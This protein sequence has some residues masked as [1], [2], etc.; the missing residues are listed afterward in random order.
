[1]QLPPG[2]R[3][4][5]YEVLAPIE[6]G[7]MG[8]VYRG[9]D[10]RLLRDVA[11]KVLPV[12]MMRDERAVERFL[13]EARA[14]AALSHPNIVAIH[15]V[16]EAT[17]SIPG[18]FGG[19]E[20]RI[21][22]LV[23]EYVD[24]GS[25]RRA[26]KGSWRPDVATAVGWAIGILRALSA[27]HDKGLIHRDLKP[28]N[29][30]VD[31]QGNA[32]IADFGLV[33]WIYP[34]SAA[35][36]PREEEPAGPATL[37][38]TGFVVGTLGYMSP[39]QVRGEPVDGRSD[40]FAFGVLVFE[41]L[42][43]SSPFA[44][45]SPDTALD[46]V[47]N[48][49]PSSLSVL[50]AGVP[51]RLAQVVAWCLEK[52]PGKRPASA[53]ALL[54]HLE[55]IQRELAAAPVEPTAELPPLPPPQ[56]ARRGPSPLAWLAGALAV[57]LA[58]AGGFAAGRS[59]PAPAPEATL[60]GSWTA[61]AVPLPQSA[62]AEL[63]LLPS[64][65]K[66]LLGSGELLDTTTG[67]LRPRAL[68]GGLTGLA[69]GRSGAAV[70][71]S[72][73]AG[74]VEAPLPAGTPL[75]TLV[76]GA[77]EPAFSRD[78]S[79][80]AYVRREGGTSELWIARRDATEARRVARAEAT[81]WAWPAFSADGESLL[82]FDV[83]RGGPHAGT[84]YLFSVRIADGTPVPFG[85]DVRLDP[86]GRPAVTRDGSVAVLEASSRRALLLEREGRSSVALPFGAGL[87]LL[88]A[89]PEGGT[90]ATRSESGPLV[91]WRRV[92]GAT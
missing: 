58:F 46:A 13:R 92:P 11:V 74:V 87:V 44:R 35:P 70:A 23:E 25:L 75:R 62:P 10:G 90:L 31:G 2:T 79:R 28:E 88:T 68:G 71:A 39:E 55:S 72:S 66:A 42:T 7:G 30:L 32:K 56:A 12:G 82:F 33:R 47:L 80:L 85:P 9:R 45:S 19:S 24:G 53:R 14:A 86:R 18:P 61:Q 40:L 49:E 38:Q 37:T 34:Q 41:L 64:G 91:L 43:G 57:L 67:A 21:R 77:S 73:A 29:V 84:G 78:E 8:S 17:V 15:D 50:V 20:T 6:A 22:Y 3:L 36:T 81:F 4:G 52:Q 5:P 60:A 26:L 51:E 83:E 63:A 1:M 89:S 48:H 27:A 69:V 59:R 76:P 54:P 16:G 65:R